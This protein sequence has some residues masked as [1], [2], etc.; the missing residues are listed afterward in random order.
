MSVPAAQVAAVGK[1][2]AHPQAEAEE[3]VSQSFQSPGGRELVLVKAEQELH[4]LVK[5]IQRQGVSQQNQHHDQQGRHQDPRPAFNSP[6][7]SSEDHR[8]GQAHEDQVP[9]EVCLDRRVEASENG[10]HIVRAQSRKLSADGEPGVVE[11]PSGHHAVEGKED[12]SRDDSQ[13]AHPHPGA[14]G[15]GQR[16][17]GSHRRALGG[18]PDKD[19]GDHDRQTDQK[20][21]SQVDE[22]EDASTVLAGH[23]GELPDVAQPHRR[24]G[25]SQDETDP[26][27]PMASLLQWCFHR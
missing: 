1:H 2:R 26:G 12:E 14:P 27:S 5:S 9:K 22:D 15:S 21:T 16:L 4:R 3:G 8:N 19:L 13:P 20:H 6:R 25:S 23:V 7:D 10:S 18:A 17:E 24:T 11:R